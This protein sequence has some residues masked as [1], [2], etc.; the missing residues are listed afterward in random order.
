MGIV[1]P[2]PQKDELEAPLHA[3]AVHDLR[4][5]RE[6]MEAAAP[7]TAVP[8]VGVAAMGVIALVAAALAG[9]QPTAV[10]WLWVWFGAATLALIVFGI[11][12]WFKARSSG[13]SLWQGSLRRFILSLC[14]PMGTGALL[15]IA[16][17][18]A[19]DMHPIPGM[20]LL[21]YGTG[22]VTGGAYSAIRVVPIMG[23]CFLALGSIAL[24]APQHWGDALLAIGFG[25]LHVVFGAIIA[26]RYGG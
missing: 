2:L 15:T 11:A 24:F 17:L 16:M 8:G 7:K 26:R 12:L 14:T 6:T 23:I 25:G 22:V 9:M 1:Q 20:W 13:V 21:L 18:H 5:I 3:R 4:F 10:R 19:R